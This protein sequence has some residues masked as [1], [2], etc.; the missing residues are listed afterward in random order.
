MTLLA[1][2]GLGTT[3]LLIFMGIL[4]LLFGSAKL[5]SLMRNLGRSANEFKAGMSDPISATKDESDDDAG[6]KS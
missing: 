1:I 5:P 4:L 6:A 3:E 2:L